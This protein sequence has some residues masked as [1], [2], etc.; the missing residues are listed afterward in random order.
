MGKAMKPRED[1]LTD[2]RG[3][4][5]SMLSQAREVIKEMAPPAL[6]SAEFKQKYG[7]G[8]TQWAEMERQ[9]GK[10]SMDRIKQDINGG[11]L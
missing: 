4:V 9:V 3:Q 7:M 10:E 5:K 8:K 11:G 6:N 1:I 2:I